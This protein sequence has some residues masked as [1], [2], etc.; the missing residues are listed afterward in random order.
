MFVHYFTAFLP[1][2]WTLNRI[3]I[4]F[5]HSKCF[6]RSTEQSFWSPCRGIEWRA[7][8][9]C[10][11]GKWRC[12]AS[13]TNR[14]RH[15]HSPPAA[16]APQTTSAVGACQGNPI[17]AGQF[18]PLLSHGKKRTNKEEH[19]PPPPLSISSNNT[20]DPMHALEDGKNQHSLCR[21]GAMATHTNH[22]SHLPT[23]YS[24]ISWLLL[25]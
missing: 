11:R 16:T 13:Q 14:T 17:S 12:R 8:L 24:S 19:S 6:E 5:F 9:G 18:P 25:W 7:L 4:S 21:A 23:H 3:I 20:N 2:C 22:S 10:P 15:E 1:Q